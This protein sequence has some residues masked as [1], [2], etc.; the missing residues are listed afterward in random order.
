MKIRVIVVED[1]PAILNGI[2]SLIRQFDLPLEV[3]GSFGNGQAALQN[4]EALKP[5]IVIT[6]V[7]MPLISGLELIRRIKKIGI[8][9]EYLVLSGYSDFDYV[10]EALQLNVHN[11]LLKPPRRTE[12]KESLGYLCEKIKKKQYENTR[13]MLQ[14]LVTKYVLTESASCDLD[15]VQLLCYG[16][17]TLGRTPQL[18]QLIDPNLWNNLSILRELENTGIAADSIWVLDALDP[19]IKFVVFSPV[20][21]QQM[22]SVLDA[23]HHHGKQLTYPMSIVIDA[24]PRALRDLPRSC[25]ACQTYLRQSIRFGHSGIIRTVRYSKETQMRFFSFAEQELL[26]R[27]IHVGDPAALTDHIRALT[28]KWSAQSVPQFEYYNAARYA[29]VELAKFLEQSGS[30]AE[31]GWLDTVEAIVITSGSAQEYC[32]N[33]CRLLQKMHLNR[34][35]TERQ[36]SEVVDEL[37][38]LIRKDYLQEINVTEFAVQNGYHV[39]YLTTQ[40]SKRK[41]VSPKKMVLNMRMERAMELLAGTNVQIKAIAQMMGYYDLS[42]F[43]RVFKDHTG[44]SPSTFRE[45]RNERN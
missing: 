7:Q 17:S 42:H 30:E 25:Q 23:L 5:Q 27:I 37:E 10:K 14:R 38:A 11:Y 8:E 9:A 39:N 32:E 41:G 4:I 21:S 15:A 19:Y 26:Q 35:R 28:E 2:V 33:L 31:A 45:N 1:E 43:S 44:E 22:Q 6:D 29:V 16:A 3:V 13:L 20:N 36:I 24:A 18:N 34:S 40:F 12:L